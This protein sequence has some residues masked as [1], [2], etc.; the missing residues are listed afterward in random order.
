M[1][2]HMSKI[3][4]YTQK[5]FCC[6]QTLLKM[7]LE[8]LDMENPQLIRAMGGLCGGIGNTGHACGAY[9]GG[10][11]LLALYISRGSESELP[12]P[13][14]SLMLSEYTQWFEATY[15]QAYGGTDCLTILSNDPNNRIERCPDIVCAVFEKVEE[16][17]TQYGFQMNVE[18]EASL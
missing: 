18:R 15:T 13:L 14:E 16:L 12:L 5:G 11:C 6:S 10:A 3:L 9:T 17:L 4:D 7:G 1:Y 8:A 2:D